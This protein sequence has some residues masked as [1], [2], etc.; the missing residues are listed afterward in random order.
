VN[1]YA[2]LFLNFIGDGA[3]AFNTFTVDAEG[4]EKKIEIVIN[5]FRVLYI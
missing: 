2:W 4:N 3:L 1:K 5:K